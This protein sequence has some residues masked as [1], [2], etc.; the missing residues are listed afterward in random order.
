MTAFLLVQSHRSNCLINTLPTLVSQD[1]RACVWKPELL[2]PSFDDGVRAA[3][4]HTQTA[5]ISGMPCCY[6]SFLIVFKSTFFLLKHRTWKFTRLKTKSIV[7]VIVKMWQEF[8]LMAIWLNRNEACTQLFTRVLYT[9]QR[10]LGHV[11]ALCII[12]LQP[13][14]SWIRRI[15]LNKKLG[16]YS[17]IARWRFLRAVKGLFIICTSLFLFPEDAWAGSMW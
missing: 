15:V 1:V 2:S 11:N 9:E 3:V 17:P 13:S 12:L 6:V 14:G 7:K 10:K 4:A 5:M 16:S 8:L